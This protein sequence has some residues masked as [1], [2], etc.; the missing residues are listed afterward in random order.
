V[1]KSVATLAGCLL[2]GALALQALAQTGNTKGPIQQTS[3]T[4]PTMAAPGLPPVRVAVVNINKVLK[5]FDKAQQMNAFIQAKLEAY[6]KSITSKR[7]E[8]VKL[9]ADIQKS[10]DPTAAENMKKRITQLQREMQDLDQEARKEIGNQQGTIAV[11]IY[12]NI[13]GV[14]QRVAVMNNFDIVLSYPDAVSDTEMYAQANVVRKLASQAAIP[15][16]YKPHVD[17]TDA[18]VQTLNAT[19][20]V[21][22]SPVQTPP[23]GAA[24]SP[25]VGSAQVQPKLK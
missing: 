13:E 20:P 8:M 21:P 3:G 19:Y 11:D 25:G 10:V 4:S 17:V 12:K 5:G 2:A 1:N 7:D 14:I 16:Y 18:V 24:P 23:T 6:G 15:I 9:E 22:K